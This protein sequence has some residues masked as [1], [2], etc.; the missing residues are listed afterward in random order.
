MH[1]VTPARA[2]FA[3]LI[4]S[5]SAHA[6]CMCVDPALAC[7]LTSP[8][9]T[10]TYVSLCKLPTAVP[11]EISL[12]SQ[13]PSS[14]H[15]RRPN[16]S[17]A[18]SHPPESIDTSEQAPIS[19]ERAITLLACVKTSMSTPFRTFVSGVYVPAPSVIS[20][21]LTS[22]IQP[23]EPNSEIGVVEEI[24]VAYCSCVSFL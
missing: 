22:N 6:Q 15:G 8:L 17:V 3:A 23:P 18:P 19:V 12:G 10:A 21:L 24:V 9:D 2:A 20:A 5:L 11:D 16:W 14:D 7:L 1:L 4:L 13:Q